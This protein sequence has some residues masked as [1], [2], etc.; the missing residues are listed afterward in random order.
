MLLIGQKTQKRVILIKSLKHIFII[1]MNTILAR[2]SKM[3]Q[4]RLCLT[5]AL[6]N[7]SNPHTHEEKESNINYLP[8]KKQEKLTTKKTTTV[9]EKP[10]I[11]STI[12]TTE[13]AK[14]T[15]KTY[16]VM[17]DLFFA[18]FCFCQIFL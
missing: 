7:Q 15:Y 5:F 18:I 2:S 11:E 1:D 9:T 6:K 16:K 17:P 3:N 12:A 14:Y 13:G 8:E 10:A 4:S